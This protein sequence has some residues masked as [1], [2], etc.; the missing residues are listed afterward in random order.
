[1][2]IDKKT[3]AFRGTTFSLFTGSPWNNEKKCRFWIKK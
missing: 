2:A 1:M 3:Y